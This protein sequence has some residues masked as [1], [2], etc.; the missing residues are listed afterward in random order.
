[1]AVTLHIKHASTWP[2]IERR[3]SSMRRE[4]CQG[5]SASVDK[6]ISLRIES[7]RF[8]QG[9]VHIGRSLSAKSG[10]CFRSTKAYMH[11]ENEQHSLNPANGHSC[12]S[13]DRSVVNQIF[14]QMCIVHHMC[15][16]TSTREPMLSQKQ[17]PELAKRI[18]DSAP[19]SKFYIKLSCALVWSKWLV[20]STRVS[21]C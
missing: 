13:S 14:K 4:E 3:D 9:Q 5:S 11:D 1:M 8:Q 18:I 7:L 20:S 12:A 19:K 2:V 6:I 17:N 21:L 10:L 16:I 15:N